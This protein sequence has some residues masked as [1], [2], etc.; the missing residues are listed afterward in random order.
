MDEN[1][2]TGHTNDYANHFFDAFIRTSM[3]K[4]RDVAFIYELAKNTT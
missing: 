1:D 2:G 3:F 4:R